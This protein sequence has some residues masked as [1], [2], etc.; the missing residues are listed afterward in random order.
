[1]HAP[2]Q[3]RAKI[4]PATA[5]ARKASNSHATIADSVAIATPIITASVPAWPIAARRGASETG[6]GG[7]PR[8]RATSPL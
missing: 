8:R 1:M 5:I 7:S 6:T 2:A 3:W 4:T